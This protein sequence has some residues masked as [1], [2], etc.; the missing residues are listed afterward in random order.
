MSGLNNCLQVSERKFIYIQKYVA[1]VWSKTEVLVE[2]QYYFNENDDS[3][4]QLNCLYAKLFTHI[5]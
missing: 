5:I 2:K 3:Y 4:H 1:Y